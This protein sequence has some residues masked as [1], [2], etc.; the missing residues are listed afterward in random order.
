VRWRKSGVGSAEYAAQHDLK[1]AR[2]LWWSAQVGKNAADRTPSR[3]LTA[4]T[5]FVPLRVREAESHVDVALA[6]RHQRADSRG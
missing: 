6:R 2:L 3:V 4:P 1:R 5:A